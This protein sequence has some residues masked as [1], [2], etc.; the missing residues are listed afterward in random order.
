MAI[1]DYLAEAKHGR[2]SKRPRNALQARLPERRFGSVRTIILTRRYVFKFPGRWTW[3]GHRWWWDFLLRGLLSNMQERKFAAEGWS[4]L[5]PVCFSVPGGF[6]V[7]MPRADPLTDGEW[8]QL[9]Y[10][11]FVTRGDGYVKENFDTLAGE[12]RRGDLGQPLHCL[13]FGN[14]EPEAGIVPAEYKRDS[15]GVL[16][17]RVVAVDYG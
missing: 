3:S 15:F 17:K 12:W 2:R 16:K 1:S 11:A 9:D 6:L 10:R 8:Q 13:V 14:A 4:E 5:C 7:V